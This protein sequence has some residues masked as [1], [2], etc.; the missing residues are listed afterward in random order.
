MVSDAINEGNT[1]YLMIDIRYF[2]FNG[3]DYLFYY[4]YTNHVM[5]NVKYRMHVRKQN[6]AETKANILIIW[7]YFNKIIIHIKSR[8]RRRIEKI[9][10]IFCFCS[11]HFNIIIIIIFI[12]SLQCN[13]EEYIIKLPSHKIVSF[14]LS[15]YFGTICVA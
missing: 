1:I 8:N 5:H 14:V 9:F 6:K 3:S 13:R 11:L 2:A 15:F 10:T 4:G 12:G 7:Q